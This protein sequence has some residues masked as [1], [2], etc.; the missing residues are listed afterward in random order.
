MKAAFWIPVFGL[1]FGF[2]MLRPARADEF[3]TIDFPGAFWTEVRGISGNVYV[4][5]YEI[6]GASGLQGFRWDGTTWTTLN[7]PGATNSRFT[8]SAG[9]HLL[10]R[11]S[12]VATVHGFSYLDGEWTSLDFPGAIET[13][14]LGIDRNDYT[15]V[16]RYVDANGGRHGFIKDTSGWSTVDY[17]G[18]VETAVE[19]I[20]G[21]RIVGYYQTADYKIHSFICDSDL[22]TPLDYP[23]ASDTQCWAASG[24]LIVGE[25]HLPNEDGRHGFVYDG[26]AWSL[27]DV[28]GALETVVEGIEGNRVVGYYL[29]VYYQG[30]GFL[31]TAS[32]RGDVNCDG[33]VDFDDINPFVQILSD[34]AGWQAAHPECPWQ[35]GDCNR[36][37]V[38][39]FA[40]ISPF[41]ALLT[42]AH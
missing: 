19:D 11:W 30:H 8:A 17:P 41:V 26:L 10:G 12:D 23:D 39:N 32:R 7:Y 18:P 38:V 1:C 6:E 4:G 3:L 2:S 28:P 25:V 40:D 15:I 22:W 29:D 5:A 20:A 14:A 16:G 31:T 21:T 34:L 33:R 36:D 9:N 42:G 37:G 13:S 24:D 35:N 27:I